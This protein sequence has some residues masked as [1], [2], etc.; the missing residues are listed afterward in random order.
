MNRGKPR[1]W[2]RWRWPTAARR[3]RALFW[4]AYIVARILRNDP[5]LHANG[6]RRID[7]ASG[8]DEARMVERGRASLRREGWS[9]EGGRSR[10]GGRSEAGKRSRAGRAG[11]G[12]LV[13]E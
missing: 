13:W 7:A 10:E 3:K 5:I 4:R 8:W 9:E 2:L 11:L 6:A 12:G 1:K